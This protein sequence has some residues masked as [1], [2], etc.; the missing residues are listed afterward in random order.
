VRLRVFLTSRPEVPIRQRF[1]QIS[2]IEHH[3]CVLHNVSPSIVDHDISI[4][5]EH[6]LR[7]IG[8]ESAQDNGWPGAEVIKTLVWRASGLFI[9]AA[10]ACRFI[11]EGLFAEERLRT[12]LEGGACGAAAATPE[13]RLNRIYVIVLQNSIH[14]GFTQQDKEMF[15]S[16]LKDILGSIVALFSPLSVGSLSRLTLIP[17]QR[18]DLMLK[19][20]HAILDIPKDHTHRL[21]LHHP[22]F[23]DFLL[24]KTRCSDSNFWVDG[25]QAHRTLAARCIKLMSAFLKQDICS[26]DSPGVLAT[27]I[28]SSRVEQYLPLD[29]QYACLYWVEHL[30]KGGTP[31]QDND[32]VHQFLK[33]HLLHWLEALGWMRRVPDGIYAI[34][35]LESIALVRQLSSHLSMT[36]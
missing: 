34:T 1:N 2:R 13:E 17:E 32:Q 18:V 33:E 35:S 7:C 15:Y 5:L 19:D 14:Q 23:R 30:Q 26:V 22:S 9:W 29:V 10:T 31:L 8:E 16:I 4:F 21:R 6:E 36:S 28:E 3:D 27:G 20:L 24:D 11:R 25:K 12:L